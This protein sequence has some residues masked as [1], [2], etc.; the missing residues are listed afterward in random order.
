MKWPSLCGPREELFMSKL[1][2]APTTCTTFS[3]LFQIPTP[4]SI[5]I[6][7]TDREL[8]HDGQVE[9][10]MNNALSNITDDDGRRSELC[11]G[12]DVDYVK[13]RVL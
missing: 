9:Q 12:G 4:K 6:S 3:N 8:Y 13:C 2:L 1:I 11:V 7:A 5:V 10:Q